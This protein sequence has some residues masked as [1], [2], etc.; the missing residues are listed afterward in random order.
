MFRESALPFIVVLVVCMAGCLACG[1]LA[2]RKGYNI[3]IW[4]AAG[5]LLVSFL[6]LAFLPFVNKESEGDD[7]RFEKTG[8]WI[9]AALAAVSLPSLASLILQ[10]VGAL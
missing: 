4:T 10:I 3:Y 1:V 9:G 7:K 8:N 6:V 2:A 5:G